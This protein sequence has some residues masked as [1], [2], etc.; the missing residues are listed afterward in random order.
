MKIKH[1]LQKRII[2]TFFP[3]RCVLCDELIE[4]NRG[5]C[6]AC[7]PDLPRLKFE[8]CQRCGREKEECMCSNFRYYYEGIYA[9][10]YYEGKLA[11]SIRNFKFN[12]NIQNAHF[13][14][15]EIASYL[16]K[17]IAVEEIDLITCV[18]LSKKS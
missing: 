5:I 1:E 8:I 7:E 12:A 15:D 17:Q 6:T 2:Y 9:P 14:A 13:F 10:F 16:K 3:R 11:K 18:P 4:P